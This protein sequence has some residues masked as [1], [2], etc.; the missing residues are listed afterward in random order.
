MFGDVLFAVAVVLGISPLSIKIQPFLFLILFCIK[1]SNF[2]LQLLSSTNL[3]I[4]P[5]GQSN[6]DKALGFCGLS[7]LEK[8]DHEIY[9]SHCL[10]RDQTSQAAYLFYLGDLIHD[11]V[12][13]S[14]R[15]YEIVAAY[16][17]VLFSLK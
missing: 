13:V 9:D 8:Q 12:E 5:C 15:I 14:A 1:P 3:T 6:G 16:K 11:E 4:I 10:E 17:Y 7:C 2:K